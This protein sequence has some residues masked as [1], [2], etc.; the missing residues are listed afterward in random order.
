MTRKER[1]GSGDT[2]KGSE[3]TVPGLLPAPVP[4][5]SVQTWGGQEGRVA[6]RVAEPSTHLFAFLGVP[7]KKTT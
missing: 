4:G 2:R 1:E 7:D 6:Q 5:V 3:N